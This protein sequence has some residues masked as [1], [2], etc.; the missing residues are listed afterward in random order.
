MNNTTKKRLNEAMKKNWEYQTEVFTFYSWEQI[1]DS[2]LIATDKR[3]ITVDDDMVDMFLA[4][5]IEVAAKKNGLNGHSNGEVAVVSVQPIILQTMN[6][7]T[8]MS[9]AEG[10]RS[11]F[12]EL[13]KAK[14]PE[15][16]RAL[17]LKASNMVKITQAVTGMARL[18]FDLQKE[19]RGRKVK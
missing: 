17:S 9:I 13:S 18:E 1:D 4:G 6:A 12:D 5:L 11:V 2:I 16:I 7:E 19:A 3:T 10:L 15:T 14:S 8:Q